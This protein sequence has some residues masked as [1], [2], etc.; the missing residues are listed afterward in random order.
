VWGNGERVRKC[1]GTERHG[2]SDAGNV[3]LEAFSS[4]VSF[5]VWLRSGKQV[6]AMSISRSSERRVKLMGRARDRAG[7][8]RPYLKMA[9]PETGVDLGGAGLQ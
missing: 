5:L 3:L 4:G 2:A 1:R 7:R 6:L 8:R 9:L